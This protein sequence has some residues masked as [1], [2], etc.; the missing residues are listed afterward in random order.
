MNTS[1]L[2]LPDISGFTEFV[3]N[4]EVEHS[5]HVISELLEVLIEANTEQ[6]QLAEIEGDALFFYK[7]NEIPSLERLLAQVEHM[8]TAF[9]SHL[10]LLEK[11]RICPCNA[12]SSAP[13]LQLKIVAHCG[14]LQYITVQNNRKPFGAQVIEAHRL[15]KNSV[16]SDNYVL[17]S[18]NLTSHIGL[19]EVY[20]TKLF[21]F[22]H[23]NNTYDGKQINY[24]FSIIDK[25][26]L[27]LKPLNQAKTVNLDKPATLTFEKEFPI[28]ANQL[29]EYITNYSYRKHWVKHVNDFEFKHNEVTRIGS[30]HVCVINED[31]FNFTTII[32]DVKPGELVYGEKTTSPPP[33]DELYQFFVITPLTSNT[34]KLTVDVHLE[35]KSII[36][37]MIILMFM[38]KA[39]RKNIGES[40]EQLF[41]F[42]NSKENSR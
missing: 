39:M 10:K 37:K 31:H 9:Y 4:T 38:K 33:V 28:S 27:K 17:L 40:V 41:V 11:N 7:E 24:L 32:K 20:Q 15:M 3:Q 16:A 8:F 42:V 5:Q 18:E 12:C 23:G 36:K 21:N 14:D 25:N 29:L 34:C 19:T 26:E 2:F 30:E 6:L 35:A 13:K 1:L 22:N